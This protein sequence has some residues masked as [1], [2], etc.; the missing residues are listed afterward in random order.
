[1]RDSDKKEPSDIVL[2]RYLFKRESS[3]DIVILNTLLLN[4]SMQYLA[5]LMPHKHLSRRLTTKQFKFDLYMFRHMY[6]ELSEEDLVLLKIHVHKVK[7]FT[8]VLKKKFC[9]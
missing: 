2:N 8:A 3:V 9:S 1:V 6:L 7:Y 4:K 5:S